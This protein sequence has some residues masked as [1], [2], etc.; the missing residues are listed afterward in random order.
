MPRDG[1]DEPRERLARDRARSCC[2]ASCGAGRTRCAGR[3][4]RGAVRA[5]D[6]AAELRALLP[7]RHQ[8]LSERETRALA[9]AQL[10]GGAAARGQRAAAGGPA[11]HLDPDRGAGG[12]R[13]LRPVRRVQPERR[14]RA[15]TPTSRSWCG[16]R[17]PRRRSRLLRESF[18]DL[19]LLLLD[20][21]Q[22]LAHAVLDLHRGGQD[23][24]P[25][26]AAQP[27]RWRC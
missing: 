13:A 11:V 4:D 10:V 26:G 19:H 24:L 3:E 21:V 7:H 6:V 27:P 14:R 17:P 12:P 23:P 25:R 16:R 1:G 9:A 8:P 20:L 18:E 15:S 5:R 22:A 2:A